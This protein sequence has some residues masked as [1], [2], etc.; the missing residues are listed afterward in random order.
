V[1]KNLLANWNNTFLVV[2][3]VLISSTNP[4]ILISNLSD[5]LKFIRK[6]KVIGTLMDPNRFF[7][8]A[9]DNEKGKA[10]RKSA[11]AIAALIRAT[12]GGS[13]KTEADTTKSEEEPLQDDHGPKTASMPDPTIYPSSTLEELIDVGSLLEH[14]KERA[15]AMLRKCINALDSTVASGI[16]Q[17]KCTLGHWM[18]KSQ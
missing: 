18:A 9:G 16:I 2:P 6:G 11:L 1:Q 13:K 14:L 7:D 15:W 10:L 5:H 3:N 4:I 12:M 17:Q 8:I